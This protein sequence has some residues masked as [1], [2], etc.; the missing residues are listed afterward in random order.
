MSFG[1]AGSLQTDISKEMENF[2]L[3]VD[4][5]QGNKHFRYH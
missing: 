1:C 5:M 2:G 3:Y 4:V